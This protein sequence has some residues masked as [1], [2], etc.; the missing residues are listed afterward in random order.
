VSASRV[1]TKEPARVGLNIRLPADV[2]RA[3][4]VACAA[5]DLTWDEAVAEALSQWATAKG[6]KR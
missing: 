4:K 5:L 1:A 2:H 6:V 3:A